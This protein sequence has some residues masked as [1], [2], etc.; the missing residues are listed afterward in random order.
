VPNLNGRTFAV[1]GASGNLGRAVRDVLL[2]DGANVVRLDRSD[3]S[4]SASTNPKQTLSLGGLDLTD[5]AAVGRALDEAIARFGRIHGLVA[6]IGAF[7]G[8]GT[9]SE[10]GW[11]V[12]DDML[13]ANLKTTVA[14]VQAIVP[15]LPREGGRRP[16]R[17]RRRER[18]ECLLSVESC[19]SASHGEPLGGAQAHWGDRQQ[20]AAEHH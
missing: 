15:R 14:A 3:H 1:T 7:S 5:T 12:W 11:T 8:G 10:D 2:R 9:G 19:G 6:T 16:S 17:P 20:R 4:G 18:I 13:T